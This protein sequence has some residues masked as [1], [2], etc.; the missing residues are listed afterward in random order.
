M[1][2]SY[3]VTEALFISFVMLMKLRALST[4]STVDDARKDL[5]ETR[6]A[7][8]RRRALFL[9]RKESLN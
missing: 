5:P 8:Q 1:D 2:G 3:K 6:K 4:F 7:L 9:M